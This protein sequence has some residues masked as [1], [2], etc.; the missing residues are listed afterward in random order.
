M[1]T[2]FKRFDDPRVD[3]TGKLDF[4][5]VKEWAT[6]TSTPVVFDFNDKAAEK[7]FG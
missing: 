1:I 6:K 4:D 7:L 5:E 3:Y 2:M